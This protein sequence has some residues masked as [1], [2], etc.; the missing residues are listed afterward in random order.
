MARPKR[1]RTMHTTIPASLARTQLGSLLRELA[2]DKRRFLITKGGKPAGV[3]LD[4]EV[5]ED[6]LDELDPAFQK[7]LVASEKDRLEGRTITLA[8]LVKRHVTKAS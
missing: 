5:Y 4:P 3:L 1:K 7:K 6:M 8:E 2:S